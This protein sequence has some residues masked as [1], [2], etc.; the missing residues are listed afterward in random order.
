MYRPAIRPMLSLV[1]LTLVVFCLPLFA[2]ETPPPEEP[3]PAVEEPQK[4]SEEIVVTARKR[5]ET[6]QD[7]PVSVAAPTESQLRDRGADTL[8][9]ISTNV[10]GFSVQNLGPG[11]S[12][13]TM[14]GVS[15]GQIVRD[16]PGVKEQVG[17]Y[18]DESVISLSLFT[19]DVD[20]FDVSRVEILRGPQGTLFGSGSLSGTVRYITN[21]PQ[22]GVSESVAELN[23][24]SVGDGAMGGSVKAAV[25]VPMSENAAM[26]VAAYYTSY[27]G[28]IDAVQPDLSVN[29]DVNGGDRI[30]ARVAF[31]VKPN[32]KLSITPRLLYQ[33]VNM[34]GWNRT[35]DFNI[36]GNPFT[37]TRPQVQLGDRRQFTQI[38]E[39]YTDE[40]LLGDLN[41]TYDLGGNTLTS[42]TSYTDRDVLVIRDATALTASIT[43]GSI[44][45]GPSVYN[46]DAPLFDATQAKS[47]TQ[48]LRISGTRQQLQWLAGLF[49]SDAERDYG[50]NLPV[51]GFEA[52][53]RALG[54]NIPTAGTKLA[55][56]DELYKSDLHYEFK[57][58][59]LFG[60]GT[61]AVTPQF[62]VTAGLRYYD[63]EEDRKQIF[64]GIFA[65][66]IDSVGSSSADGFAPRV[67]VSYK[68]GDATRLNAQV[69]KGFRLGGINDPLNTP[70]CTAQDLA[71][72]GGHPTWDDESLWNYEAG[73]KTSVM[74]GRGTLNASV[75]RMDIENLQATVTAGSCSSR[76]ILNVPDAQSTGVEAEFEVAPN[77][78]FDF[79]ISGSFVN[80]E[81]QSTF[82]DSAGN[83]VAGIKE[84]NRL[85]TVPE[86]QMAAAATYRWPVGT[87]VAYTTGVYQHVGDRYTQIGD[88]AEGFGRVDLTSFTGDIGG[89]YSQNIFTFDPKLPA[90]DLVNLRFGVLVG[91]WD[92]ALFINNL[93]DEEA[94]LALD[95]ER[96]SRARVGHLTNQP[97]TIGISTRVTF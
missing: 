69:S 78:N 4:V 2:Q 48:E 41:I 94:F 65:D 39:P 66:P 73:V 34:D 26:R 56:T 6:V 12:Q 86:F 54:V 42:V 93:T 33:E 96:G 19:P 25:N 18:L 1:I 52:A 82:R 7:V 51:I 62:D 74:G 67:I 97:R 81:L 27:A 44:G 43:G 57:Q 17:V 13:V 38:E 83:V 35:D 15:A 20:L 14:R 91:K 55:L 37:T 92:A 88:Q 50:Q 80:S 36:L 89:P 8:E 60:E 10:A 90:Y 68:L 87:F 77:E 79:A 63:F 76:I 72:Y 70:L 53:A 46:I 28:F 22:I 16:Q 30:G 61:W 85:P 75:Y 84:G 23:V 3:K 45:L 47:M 21:Q 40:F 11:Q 49:Y 64:D 32:D 59:A 9:D 95:Q 29:K 71:I 24:N 5:E 58:V 31:L